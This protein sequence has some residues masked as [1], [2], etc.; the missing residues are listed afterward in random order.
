MIKKTLIIATLALLF[1]SMIIPSAVVAEEEVKATAGMSS[2]VKV[3][4]T[5]S[6]EPIVPVD[7]IRYYDIN[8]TYDITKGWFISSLLLPFF[9]GKQV[10][11]NLEIV[12]KSKWCTA[13]LVLGTLTTMISDEEQSMSTKLSVE[14]DK[15]APAYGAGYVRLNVSVEP[16]KGPLG[17]ITF[18]DGYTQEFTI[19]FKPAYLPLIQAEFPQ[20][21]SI[22]IAPYNETKIS[23]DVSNLGNARTIVFFEI[24]NTSKSFNVSID[25]EILIDVDGKATA[26]I[27]IL[28]DHKF[29]EE[30]I[31][32]KLTPARAENPSQDIG[33]PIYM[34]LEVKNDGSYVEDE[35]GLEIDTTLLIIILVIIAF[36]AVALI[37]L[38]RK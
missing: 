14:L 9:M 21:A 8:I 19:K 30:E 1:C 22:E 33:E 24:V 15:D 4:W 29:D 38:K 18:I 27:I 16:F 36:V 20:A 5:A 17:L 26:D 37:I 2:Y 35:D 23:L 12:D 28:A 25:S 11:I 10:D 6:N 3:N 31:K 13:N 34:T 7:E 32:I